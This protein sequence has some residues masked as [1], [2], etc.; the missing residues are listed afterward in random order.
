MKSLY[1]NGELDIMLKFQGVPCFLCV[2]VFCFILF[3]SEVRNCEL[4]KNKNICSGYKYLEL[5]VPLK[6]ILDLYLKSLALF[7]NLN[8]IILLILVQACELKCNF[9]LQFYSGTF[10]NLIRVLHSLSFVRQLVEL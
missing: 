4:N 2:R 10:S 6:S 9:T 5:S 8:F 3:F 7:R 1:E